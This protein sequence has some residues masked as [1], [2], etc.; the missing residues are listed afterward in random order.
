MLELKKY[1]YVLRS[2]FY[3]IKNRTSTFGENTILFSKADISNSTV[4]RY[5]YFAGNA[6]VINAD[7]GAFCSISKGVI[8]GL[9]THPTDFMT[10][11]PALYSAKTIFPHK[12]YQSKRTYTES[13]RVLI[14]DDVWLGRNVIVLDGV[15]IGK[16]AIVAAGAVVTKNVEPYAIYGGVPA[17]LIKYRLDSDRLI[18]ASSVDFSTSDIQSL[19]DKASDFDERIA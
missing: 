14:E 5:T 2:T 3:K 11:H 15:N 17:K 18:Y 16:G 4:G 19:I 13:K 1:L 6:S 10:T 7:I 9:G 8:I 12:L